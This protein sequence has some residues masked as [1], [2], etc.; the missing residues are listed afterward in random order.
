MSEQIGHR[1]DFV[2]KDETRLEGTLDDVNQESRTLTITNGA[3]G[4]LRTSTVLIRLSQ[5]AG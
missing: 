3:F 1:F 4:T 2:L 5:G